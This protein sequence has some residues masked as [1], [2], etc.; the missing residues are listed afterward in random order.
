MSDMKFCKD[1]GCLLGT[2]DTLGQQRFNR[3]QRCEECQKIHRAAQ[4][5]VY[6]REYRKD[7]RTV[8]RLQ[9]QQI[10]ELEKANM[11]LQK[12][13]ELKVEELEQERKRH[14]QEV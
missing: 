10:L 3:I 13:Y 9:K 5:A 4:K 1:C 2:R 7:G 14:G 8:R 6:Q 12:L 11:V